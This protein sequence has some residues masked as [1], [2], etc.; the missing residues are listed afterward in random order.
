MAN[1]TP[2]TRSELPFI[3]RAWKTAVDHLSPYGM[4]IK[5]SSANGDHAV[6]GGQPA[7]ATKRRR[8]VDESPESAPLG[9]LGHLLSESAN[10]FEQVLRVEVL[11]LVRTNAAEESRDGNLPNGNGSPPKKEFSITKI[12]CKLMVCRYKPASEVRVLWCDSQ[13]CTFKVF[14]DP[15]DGTVAKIYLPSPFYIPAEKLHLDRDDGSGFGLDDQYLVQAELETAGDPSWP[16]LDLLHQNQAQDAF[17]SHPQRWVLHSGTVYRLNEKGRKS[18]PVKLRKK[19]NDDTPLPWTMDVDMKWS[20]CHM[21]GTTTRFGEEFVPSDIKASLANGALEPLTNGHVN[22]RVDQMTNGHSKE[23]HEAAMDEDEGHGDAT[24]PTRSLRTRGKQ[25]YNLKLLSDK[26]RGRERKERKQRKLEDTGG[27]TGQVSWMLPHHG[28]VAL[29]GYSCIRCFAMHSSIRQLAQHIEAH[30][31]CKFTVDLKRS[32]IWITP[33][34]QETPRQSKSVLLDLSSPEDHV[35]EFEGDASPQKQ[36]GSLPAAN[37]SQTSFVPAKRKDPRQ[38]IPHIKQPIYDRLSKSLLEPGS[39]VDAPQV[40]DR[41]LMQKHR[42]IILEFS[43]VP[44]DEKEYISEWDAF[45]NREGVTS[46]PHLQDVYI[47]FV[48]QKASWLAASQCRMTEWAKH[49]GYLKARDSLTEA[50]VMEALAIMRRARSQVSP[51]QPEPVKTP[52]PRSEYR[53]SKSGCAVCGQPVRGASTLICSNLDCDK[54]LYH[55]GCIRA[56]AQMPVED[57]KWRCNQCVQERSAGSGTG[58]HS[59]NVNVHR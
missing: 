16:P 37:L 10:D 21:A 46:E 49:L 54:A 22:G 23:N 28:E 26:A 2:Y 15:K 27:D 24:T 3:H 30:R 31:E 20:T 1:F 41:W 59:A 18:S 40:D 8:I 7:R 56:D 13:I 4:G 45:V 19:T 43:D 29:K 32:R 39:L 38:L 34:D 53:K 35:S 52:S 9:P 14:R 6:N 33:F 36:S 25:N 51:E 5:L 55:I 11:R 44:A 50:T 17:V 47:R 57:R 12:R 48:R 58:S 42:D